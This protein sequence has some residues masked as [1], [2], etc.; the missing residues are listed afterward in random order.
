MQ[1]AKLTYDGENLIVDLNCELDH[2][3]VKNIREEVDKELLKIKPK[4]LVFDF[5]NVNFMDSSG[6][7]LILGRASKA[8]EVGAGVVLRGLSNT[9]RKLVRMSGMEKLQIISVI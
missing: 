7:G 3:T 4:A 2:H 5:K 6:I 1:N 9:Q 8:E